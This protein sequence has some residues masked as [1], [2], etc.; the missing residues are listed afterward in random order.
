LII[1]DKSINS[2]VLWKGYLILT[3]LGTSTL[4]HYGLHIH[5]WKVYKCWNYSPTHNVIVN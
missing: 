1:K 5:N 4:N 3:L 2:N